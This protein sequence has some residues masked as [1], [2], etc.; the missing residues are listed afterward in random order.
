MFTSLPSRMLS[1]SAGAAGRSSPNR[2]PAPHSRNVTS[3]TPQDFGVRVALS[4]RR[5]I[6]GPSF[7][8]D[9]PWLERPDANGPGI[10]RAGPS[11]EERYT[12]HH[13]VPISPRPQEIGLLTLP[14][15]Q[16]AASSERFSQSLPPRNV[17]KLGGSLTLWG[18]LE[19]LH[20]PSPAIPPL[21]GTELAVLSTPEASL[22]RLVPF[23][24]HLAV[25][26]TLPSVSHWVLPEQTLVL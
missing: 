24:G 12:P 11:G 9:S 13:K 3:H 25:W 23:L 4:G 21:Q 10:L 26:E 2:V 15:F 19:Q 22:E 5:R 8:H 6:C 18:Y 20:R 16:G 1:W 14:V 17:A 7:L